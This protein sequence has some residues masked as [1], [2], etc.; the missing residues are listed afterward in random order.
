MMRFIFS[1]RPPLCLSVPVLATTPF[2]AV[3][4]V[5]TKRYF[6]QYQQQL[7]EC[8]VIQTI[9]PAIIPLLSKAMNAFHTGVLGWE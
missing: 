3:C 4:A 7:L 9:T 8:F 5:G 2:K 1:D 6:L